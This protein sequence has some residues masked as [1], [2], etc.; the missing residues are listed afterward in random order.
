[1]TTGVC[2]WCQSLFLGLI[3]SSSSSVLHC[4]ASLRGFLSLHEVYGR[5]KLK[6][7]TP[8]LLLANQN[9][10]YYLHLEDEE[11]GEAGRGGAG[12]EGGA[13]GANPD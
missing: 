8:Q 13:S 6:V 11:W 4:K 7:E 10:D 12:L 5:G 1:M 9:S 3:I 2:W